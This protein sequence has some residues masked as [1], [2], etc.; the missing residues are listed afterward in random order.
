MVKPGTTSVSFDEGMHLMQSFKRIK[1]FVVAMLVIFLTGISGCDPGKTVWPG[2]KK[3][4]PKSGTTK[5]IGQ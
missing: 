4:A 5:E 3:S 1:P 2:V